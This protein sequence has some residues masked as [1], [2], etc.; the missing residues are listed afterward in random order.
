[1]IFRPEQA[2]DVQAAPARDKRSVGVK[3]RRKAGECRDDFGLVALH[4]VTAFSN[5]PVSIASIC[6][7]M[8]RE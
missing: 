1:M 6:R 3:E 5:R 7:A 2:G 4:E 8:K